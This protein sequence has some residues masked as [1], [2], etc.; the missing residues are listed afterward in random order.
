MSTC[1]NVIRRPS[2]LMREPFTEEQYFG[3]R[4]ISDPLCLYDFCME[5]DGAV[6]AVTTSAERPCDLRHRPVYVAASAH[7]GHGRWGQAITWL[8]MPDE[9]FASSGHRPVA[10]RLYDMAGV[11]PADVQVALLYDH[12]TPM[13]IMQLEDSAFAA[14]AKEVRSSLTA[15]SVG[16]AVR[17]Q[18][19]RTAATCRRRTSSA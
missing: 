16:P 7:G 15:T 2:A 13:V 9:Y 8:G 14:S 11:G 5:C 17:C 3:A 19:I 6:V 10:R 1:D 4:M 18:S 12:F